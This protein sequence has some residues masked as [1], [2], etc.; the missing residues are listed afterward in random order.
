M[1]VSRRRWDAIFASASRATGAEFERDQ[2]L[3][4]AER[5]RAEAIRL[6]ELIDPWAKSEDDD[7]EV[8]HR[9]RTIHPRRCPE[10]CPFPS[11]RETHPDVVRAHMRETHTTAEVF[12]VIDR[13]AS[14]RDQ[15]LLLVGAMT[16]DEVRDA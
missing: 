7:A 1:W 8:P 15:L 5:W 14:Q 9:R 2:A 12:T 13:L 16:R 11:E 10:V 3:A 4:E 6:A